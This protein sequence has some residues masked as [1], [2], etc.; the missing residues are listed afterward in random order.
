MAENSKDD[1]IDKARK[2]ERANRGSLTDDDL[3]YH[4][5]A[6]K[7]SKDKR[8]AAEYYKRA[9]LNSIPPEIAE[10]DAN[11]EL[12]H[13]LADKGWGAFLLHSKIVNKQTLPDGRTATSYISRASY[14]TFG[15]ERS[16]EELK[17]ILLGGG[18][19]SESD[20]KQLNMLEQE[21]RSRKKWWQFWKK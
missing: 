17:K 11:H 18:K 14:K 10:Q 13:A 3:V 21:I 4:G 20:Q 7:N 6:Y 9:L 8:R 19:L 1:Y 12:G 5:F 2:I 16:P 15:K